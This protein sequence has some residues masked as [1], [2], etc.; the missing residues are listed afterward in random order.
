MCYN[1]ITHSTRVEYVL[2]HRNTS[3]RMC[4]NLGVDTNVV[5]PGFQPV[6]HVFLCYRDVLPKVIPVVVGRDWKLKC[7]NNKNR[8]ICTEEFSDMY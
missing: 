6:T 1:T 7:R 2:P 5:L 4:Y 3:H 8:N